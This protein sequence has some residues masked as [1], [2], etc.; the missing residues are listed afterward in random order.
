MR[1]RTLP[2]KMSR[3]LQEER[4]KIILNRTMK[5]L[6]KREKVVKMMTTINLGEECSSR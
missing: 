4:K 3:I 5:I 6:R 1:D 2:K